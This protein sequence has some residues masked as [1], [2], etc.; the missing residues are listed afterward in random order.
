MR[1][2]DPGPITSADVEGAR[3][4]VRVTGE[5]DRPT[6]V[7]GHGLTSSMDDEDAAGIFDWSSITGTGRLVRYDARSHGTSS[8]GA[9]VDELRWDRLGG[10]MLA[11]A[12]AVGAESFVAGGASMGCATALF[13]ARAAP[14]RVTALV[15]VIPPTAWDTR[16]GQ[17]QLY[18]ANVELIERAGIEAA[19]DVMSSQPLPPLFQPFEARVRKR[20]RESLAAA[21]PGRIC[22]AL[23][24][25]ARSQLPSPEEVAGIGVPA[26][27]LAWEGDTGHPESTA[28]EL[29]RLLPR[30]TLHVATSLEDALGW[31]DLVHD[32][33][34]GLT[35]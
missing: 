3:L 2:V 16:A 10:D 32:F 30:S 19:A 1:E 20:R 33:F 29:D 6:L 5:G 18:E 35:G 34:V 7:W 26:L 12:D 11:V 28:R 17:A 25:A 8:S 31:R 4:A 14:E 22:T 24:G 21:D 9:T 23:R 15:L 27:V 13:A